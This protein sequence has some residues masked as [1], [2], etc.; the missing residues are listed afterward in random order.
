MGAILRAP[1]KGDGDGLA[2]GR[3]PGMTLGEWKAFLEEGAEDGEMERIRRHTR[4]GR[5]MGDDAFIK[6][7]ERRL[8]RVLRRGKPGP[9]P[10]GKGR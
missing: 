2:T 10:R 3:V 9:K 6:S 5:P 7:V 1:V 8:E 4:S